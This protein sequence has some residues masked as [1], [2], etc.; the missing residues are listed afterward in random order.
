MTHFTSLAISLHRVSP[1][2]HTQRITHLQYVSSSLL[3]YFY[4]P[5]FLLLQI[6]RWQLMRW[7][8]L[9]QS[10][11]PQ[12]LWR[13]CNENQNH[14]SLSFHGAVLKE[15][16][17]LIR[18]LF[19]DCTCS[20]FFSTTKHIKWKKNG[21]VKANLKSENG[22]PC[23]KDVILLLETLFFSGEKRKKE[24]KNQCMLW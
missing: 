16:S 1:V 6:S 22:Q 13:R 18:S 2:S 9:P 24:K 5:Y 10:T 21:N 15:L 23:R 20:F 19:F 3:P 7:H 4:T 11:R 12:T 14:N 17:P 8:G